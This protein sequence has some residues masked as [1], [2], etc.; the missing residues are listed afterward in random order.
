MVEML[1]DLKPVQ[2]WRKNVSKEDLIAEMN[3][4]MDAL[5]GIEASFSQPIRDNVLE[6]ISQIDGQ[7]VVKIFGE[8][9]NLINTKIVEMLHLISQVQGVASAYI[10]RDAREAARRPKSGK[11]RSV[12]AWWSAWRKASVEMWI[13]FAASCSTRPTGRR[14]PWIKSPKSAYRKG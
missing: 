14:C 2:E 6:S 5:P 7:I 9:S 11:A 8:D 12:L 10:D 13:P 4:A 1:V 3:T